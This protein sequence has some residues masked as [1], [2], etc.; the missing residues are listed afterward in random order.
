M[1][2]SENSEKQTRQEVFIEAEQ[3][4]LNKYSCTVMT[5]ENCNLGDWQELKHSR[6][7]CKSFAVQEVECIS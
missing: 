1:A 5:N 4:F 7:E 3:R 6:K 2:A